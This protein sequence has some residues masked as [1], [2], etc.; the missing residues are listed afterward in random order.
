MTQGD[1]LAYLKKLKETGRAPHAHE[2]VAF[3]SLPTG[4]T[5]KFEFPDFIRE[6]T[7]V[8]LKLLRS[9]NPSGKNLDVKYVGIHGTTC[10]DIDQQDKSETSIAVPSN[11][12]LRATFANGDVVLVPCSSEALFVSGEDV[13]KILRVRHRFSHHALQ[14]GLFQ[15]AK[16]KFSLE[17]KAIMSTVSVQ[18]F[19]CTSAERTSIDQPSPIALRSAFCEEDLQREVLLR[20]C[21]FVVDSTLSASVRM[22]SLKLLTT[23][24]G[25]SSSAVGVILT[26][27]SLT[28]LLRTNIILEADVNCIQACD[29][30]IGE[31]IATPTRQR[32]LFSAIVELVPDV[33]QVCVT[34]VGLNVIV[35]RMLSSCVSDSASLLTLSISQLIKLGG[36]IA[37]RRVGQYRT[38]QVINSFRLSTLS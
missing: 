8:L 6:G 34:D 37:E 24:C 19:G 21:S 28:A 11:V 27:L 1:Y 38:L 16:L 22:Y 4:C 9:R 23:T 35:S 12:Q 18:A 29:R 3:F 36:P 10:E 2:P 32:M 7:F 26:Q 30:F 17:P 31:I 14:K 5:E 13:T 33:F 25:T 20:L 15:I